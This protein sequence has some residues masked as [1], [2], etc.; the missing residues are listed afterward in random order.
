M[1]DDDDDLDHVDDGGESVDQGRNNMQF[2]KVISVRSRKQGMKR[3]HSNFQRMNWFD[4]ILFY[5]QGV[6]N[7]EEENLISELGINEEWKSS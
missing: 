6:E 3:K 7:Y 4:F 2:E 5:W 1:Y